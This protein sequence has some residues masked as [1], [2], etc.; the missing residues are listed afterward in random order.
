M[1]W[2]HGELVLN[3]LQGHSLLLFL[4]ASADDGDGDGWLVA[5]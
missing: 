5:R 3:G 2:V 4:S 1:I